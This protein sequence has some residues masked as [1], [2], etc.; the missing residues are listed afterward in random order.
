M[1]GPGSAQWKA[2]TP[3]LPP[4]S[5]GYVRYQPKAS[6]L[7]RLTVIDST[8]GALTVRVDLQAH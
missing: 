1:P 3:W 2:V 8:R 4:G 6:S 5:V 7:Y